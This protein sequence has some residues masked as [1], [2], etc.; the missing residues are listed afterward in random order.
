M[1][2]K[3]VSIHFTQVLL[4]SLV[5][6]ASIWCCSFTA[7]HEAFSSGILMRDYSTVSESPWLTDIPMLA[8]QIQEREEPPLHG[9]C[10]GPQLITKLC[11]DLFYIR[12]R[13]MKRPK[14]FYPSEQAMEPL[15]KFLKKAREWQAGADGEILENCLLPG[16]A[17]AEIAN[18]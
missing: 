18:F 2:Q 12:L 9:L 17:G 8:L 16:Q 1:K 3:S 5:R 13:Q 14:T 15:R 11:E 7:C 4:S 10:K 6:F